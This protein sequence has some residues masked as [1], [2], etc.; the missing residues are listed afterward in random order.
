[1]A[2]APAFFVLKA[3]GEVVLVWNWLAWHDTAKPFE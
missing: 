1:M 2:A 3:L